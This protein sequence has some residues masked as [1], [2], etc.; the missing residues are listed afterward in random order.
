MYADAIGTGFLVA[1]KQLN[2]DLP[3]VVLVTNGHVLPEDLPYGQAFAV[4]HGLVG[5]QESA[6]RKFEVIR[7]WWYQ[8]SRTPALDIAILELDAYPNNVKPMPLAVEMPRLGTR[9]PP[10]A[11]V[12]GHP[13][14]LDTPQ[15]S[16]QD[17]LLIDYDDTL[18]HYRS[19]TEHG[20][21]GSPVF[22]ASWSLIAVHHAGGREIPKLHR[23]GGTYP[24]NEGIA[25][26][27][28]K[29]RLVEEPPRGEDVTRHQ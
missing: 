9:T 7:W 6:R 11:Y 10:R 16:L 4:F 24:A 17:N 20:S 14:G 13:A 22:D 19:P 23:E 8:P 18:V 12:I 5:D 2:P 27:A 28:I 3:D 1:G 26:T 15:F 21:S 29:G 25:V